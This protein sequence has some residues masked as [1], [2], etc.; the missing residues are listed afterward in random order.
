MPNVNGHEQR[1]VAIWAFL[2]TIWLRRVD[3]N[4]WSFVSWRTL[5]R[6]YQ[7]NHDTHQQK[8]SSFVVYIY[9]P[10]VNGAWATSCGDMS[11]PAHHIGGGES[12]STP[13]TLPHEDTFTTIPTQPWQAQAKVLIIR[14]L[15]MYAKR[16]WGMSNELWRYEPS[17]TPYGCGESTSTPPTL[18]HEDTFTTIPT[19]PWRSRAKVR[20]IRRL[21]IYAKRK[22]G[23]SKEFRQS[24]PSCTPYWWRRVDLN[25]SS[26][27]RL[28]GGGM[29]TVDVLPEVWVVMSS[30]WMHRRDLL[31]SFLKICNTTHNILMICG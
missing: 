16:K 14:R 4:S 30:I 23:M 19:Q 9:M 26:L 7:R 21:Y 3:Y 27:S 15:Y 12:T 28:Y 13:P 20:I 8:Y 17:Y 18:P 29:S 2:H 11:L 10:N 6:L 25:S 31:K 1:V 22:W 24:G 5:L